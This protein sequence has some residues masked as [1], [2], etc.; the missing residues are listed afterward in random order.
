MISGHSISGYFDIWAQGLY[1]ERLYPE[2]RYPERLYPERTLSR[3]GLYPE[4]DIAGHDFTPNR[5]ELVVQSGA[6]GHIEWGALPPNPPT[7][8]GRLLALVL[9]TTHKPSAS[10]HFYW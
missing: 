4:K 3:N 6:S 10:I 5:L 1:P 7:P 2:R 8:S 9:T